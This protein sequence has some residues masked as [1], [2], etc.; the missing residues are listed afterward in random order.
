MASKTSQ[1]LSFDK[2]LNGE[3]IN[4]ESSKHN[5]AIWQ[6]RAN[7][8]VWIALILT[9]LFLW[10][11]GTDALPWLRGPAPFPEW[12]WLY[13]LLGWERPERNLLHGLLFLAYL[14]T[15]LFLAV[16][17]LGDGPLSGR[18]HRFAQG[19]ALATIFLLLWQLAQTWVRQTSLLDHLIFRT[20]AP[21]INGYFVAPAQVDSIWDT[22]NHYR[23]AMPTFFADKTK[24]HPPGL[25][26]FY[27][28][29][30]S[31]FEHMPRLSSWFAPIARTWAT[32]G[33]D[34]PLLMDHLVTSSFV[35]TLVQIAWVSLS[36]ISLYVLVRR[37]DR[38]DA[39]GGSETAL[40]AALLMPL[41]TP[42]TLM[43]GQWD[44]NYLP[45]AFAA[46][47]FAARGQDHLHAWRRDLR[48][49]M[50]WLGAGL[51]FSLLT[52]LSF[53]NSFIGL[54]VG[55]HILW[56]EVDNQWMVLGKPRL[57]VRASLPTV[58][59]LAVTGVGVVL[60]WLAAYMAWDMNFFALLDYGISSHYE[61]VT[62]QREYS[63]W[64][65]MNLVDFTYWLGSGLILLAAVGSV[66]VVRIWVYHHGIADRLTSNL[67]GVALS[68]WPV[69]FLL[70]FS[71]TTRGEVGRLWIFLMPYPLLLSLGLLRTPMHRVA[72]LLIMAAVHITLSYVL[73]PIG[74]C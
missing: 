16:P 19:V 72:L 39:P 32:A 42:I 29:F 51:L 47:F 13:S 27:A 3:P 57:L 62:A 59:G 46:W 52:W 20:Y 71:G 48:V 8:W 11:A 23:A 6:R 35:T 24:T 37:L 55:L 21:P 41:L 50:D 2:S 15:A 58:L 56:R 1:S 40:W 30:N 63:I 53:G 66:W 22:L 9:A 68:F 4:G 43:M 61:I 44:P 18:T 38:G 12:Q 45:I 54:L 60:P 17:Q 14:G 33:R 25:F 74:C 26:I 28:I 7:L 31:L 49:W 10:I 5:R 34:W 64:W 70:N 67:A 73:I 69:L 65:W 36:P